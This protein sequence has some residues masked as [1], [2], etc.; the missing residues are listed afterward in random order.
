MERAA[1]SISSIILLASMLP[2]HTCFSSL[3]LY[4][5]GRAFGAKSCIE[6]RPFESA[7][8]ASSMA[9][10]A[11]RMGDAPASDSTSRRGAVE[12]L[13]AL[14]GVSILAPSMA[15]AGAE[16]PQITTKV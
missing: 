7:R 12:K 4:S 14:V 1:R 13:F 6:T 15:E 9:L 16:E 10:P 5:A 2:G 8:Q 3:P 11:L